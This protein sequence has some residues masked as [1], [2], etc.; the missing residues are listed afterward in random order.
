[1]NRRPALL[2]AATLT[3]AAVFSLSAC[4]GGSGD[5]TDSDKIAGADAGDAAEKSSPSASAPADGIDRPKIVVPKDVK[6]E[7]TPETTGDAKTDAVLRDNAEYWRAIV[8]SIENQDPKSEAVRYY[9][10]GAG[11]L[12]T[13][14]WSG[15]FIKNDLTLAGTV[16][17]TDRE[18][19]FSKD[20]SAG[21]TYCS[22][23]SKG[24]TKDRKTG[25]KNVTPAG[26]DSYIRYNDRLRKN[27]D[28]VWQLTNSTSEMGS[29]LC[30]P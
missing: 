13:I 26:K 28:G 23:E 15:N 24:F 7:F 25:K 27:A 17:F 29:A 4:G 8:E 11:L 12:G 16:R 5:S 14:E 3:A 21:L 9:S 10:K 19:K 30:Q 6:L 2:T 18:V 1:M 20:G 22:D